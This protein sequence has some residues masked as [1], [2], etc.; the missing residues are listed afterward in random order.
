[1]KKNFQILKRSEKS[2]KAAFEKDSEII[3]KKIE[4]YNREAAEFDAKSAEKDKVPLP[5]SPHP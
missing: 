1:V 2:K 5:N 3:Q 4:Q